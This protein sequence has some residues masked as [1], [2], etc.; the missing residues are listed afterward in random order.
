M[1]LTEWFDR[2]L[3]LETA[4]PKLDRKLT[5]QSGGDDENDDDLTMMT[6]K[7]MMT[8]ILMRMEMEVEIKVFDMSSTQRWTSSSSFCEF[9]PNW[10][11]NNAKKDKSDIL[12]PK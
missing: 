9:S 3:V 7:R 12:K 6:T 1:G 5:N 2:D 11:Q 10:L 8:I 4:S